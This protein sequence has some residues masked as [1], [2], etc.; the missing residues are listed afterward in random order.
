MAQNFLGGSAP[1]FYFGFGRFGLRLPCAESPETLSRQWF[2][3]FYA[4]SEISPKFSEWQVK[5]S[6]LSD[7]GL[8]N[9]PLQST[10]L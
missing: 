2:Q 9:P 3:G 8:F 10:T 5:I 7:A 4:F 1:F 6:Y